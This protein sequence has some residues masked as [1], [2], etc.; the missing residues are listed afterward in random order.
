MLR[1]MLGGLAKRELDKASASASDYLAGHINALVTALEAEAELP[2]IGRKIVSFPGDSAA[3]IARRQLLF[4]ETID[5]QYIS[6][7]INFL[8][9]GLETGSK[10]IEKRLAVLRKSSVSIVRSRGNV[11]FLVRAL[12]K[13]GIPANTM[14]GNV[15]LV[16]WGS[17]SRI[18]NSSSTEMTGA[19]PLDMTRDK[20]VANTFM[21]QAGLP[22]AKQR[23]V[24]SAAEAVQAAQE[25]GY[26]VAIKPRSRDGGVGVTRYVVDDAAARRAFKRARS[27]GTSILVEQHAE[28]SEYRILFAKDQLISAHERIPARV[29]GNGTDTVSRLAEDENARK[30]KDEKFGFRSFPVIINEDARQ[31]LAE[32]GLTL[33]S[34]PAKG[35]HVRLATVP[36][37]RT[38]GEVRL[39]ERADIHPSVLDAASRAVRLFRLDVAGVDYITS[40]CSRPAGE[41]GGVITE[42]N[43]LPQINP[44]EEFDVHEAFLSVLLEGV[45]PVPSLLITDN[46]RETVEMLRELD[47]QSGSA[48]SLTG[49]I[50]DDPRMAQNLSATNMV[51][52]PFADRAGVLGD[53]SV[54]R[55]IIVQGPDSILQRGLFLPHVDGVLLSG[56]NT[57]SDIAALRSPL[58]RQNFA[59]NVIVSAQS[60]QTLALEEIFGAGSVREYTNDDQ[61]LKA[62]RE[63]LAIE[64]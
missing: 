35:A 33:S 8:R 22:V 2:A 53:T 52:A 4:I 44:Y 58:V 29:I 61:R 25:I 45:G 32:Q 62:A 16:G 18:L 19:T 15:L 12:K 27:E 40:D 51:C 46:G 43:A 31:C 37:V 17:N 41:A 39:L 56:H 26:P 6:S 38:G 42:V 5:A 34:V 3:G 11:K 28:G 57:K 64:H 14:P 54:C 55:I 23:I 1:P 10:A 20:A 7:S 59:N 63:I 24:S 30:E 36:K 13:L 47:V 49:V 21:G 48:G 60:G 9:E 50:C